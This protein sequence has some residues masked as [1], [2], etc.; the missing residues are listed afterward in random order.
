MCPNS[1]IKKNSDSLHSIMPFP[2]KITKWANAEFLWMRWSVPFIAN[3]FSLVKFKFSLCTWKSWLTHIGT[4]GSIQSCHWIY[5]RETHIVLNQLRNLSFPISTF[6]LP[7]MFT[8]ATGLPFPGLTSDFFFLASESP[9]NMFN[10]PSDE[11]GF[12]GVHTVHSLHTFKWCTFG[13]CLFLNKF[14]GR[15][16]PCNR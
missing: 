15:K 11:C 9:W 14:G 13:R 16:S 4:M 10:F 1:L 7:K 5:L 12:E 2:Y 3:A 8:L 6:I